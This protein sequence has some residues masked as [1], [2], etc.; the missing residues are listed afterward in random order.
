MNKQQKTPAT[1]TA[2]NGLLLVIVLNTAV[3]AYGIVYGSKI[4][5]NAI[6]VI[7]CPVI[8]ILLLIP[9]HY[10]VKTYRFSIRPQTKPLRRK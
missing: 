8:I 4:T 5:W 3:I 1:P 10:L 6:P 2:I 9:L 7:I